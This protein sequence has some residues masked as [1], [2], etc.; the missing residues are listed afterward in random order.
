[1]GWPSAARLPWSQTYEKNGGSG[2]HEVSYLPGLAPENEATLYPPPLAATYLLFISDEDDDGEPV[3]TAGSPWTVQIL[4]GV[5]SVAHSEVLG[6]GAIYNNDDPGDSLCLAPYK[7]R[8][9]LES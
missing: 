3:Q 6:P 9:K 7:R 5:M 2:L 1:M 4:P 8:R